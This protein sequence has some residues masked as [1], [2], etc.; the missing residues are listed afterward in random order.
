MKEEDYPELGNYEQ[1]V[2]K[3]ADNDYNEGVSR[4]EYLMNT[5]E[6]VIG[7][8][9]RAGYTV[10]YWCKHHHDTYLGVGRLHEK[11]PAEK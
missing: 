3:L 6:V 7:F 1:Y 4:S 5:G 8:G 2:V 9:T 10:N 11:D